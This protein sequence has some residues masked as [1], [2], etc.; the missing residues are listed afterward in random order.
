MKKLLLAALA[1]SSVFLLSSDIFAA[2]A[3]K[4]R[5][6]KRNRAEM[7]APAPGLEEEAPVEA[8]VKAKRKKKAAAVVVEA[9]DV[10]VP[11]AVPALEAAPVLPAP[12]FAAPVW[13]APAPAPARDAVQ[14]AEEARAEQGAVL[15][16]AFLS[17]LRAEL[18]TRLAGFRVTRALEAK[19][20]N[21]DAWIKTKIVEARIAFQAEQAKQA[22]A[23]RRAQGALVVFQPAQ[24]PAAISQA[25]A[26]GADNAQAIV[27][28]LTNEDRVAHVEEELV[29]LQEELVTGE[30]PVAQAVVAGETAEAKLARL[31][32]ELAAANADKEAANLRLIEVQSR[33]IFAGMLGGLSA[34]ASSVRGFFSG[35]S[36]GFGGKR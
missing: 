3:R 14:V 22:D 8:S 30:T 36:F 31:T 26:A 9:V 2:D 28:A 13:L 10:A 25:H 5:A 17:A 23:A 32:A 29:T 1:I 19:I 34:A 7:E 21:L 20:G 15:D 12:V 16:E 35:F 4:A 6:D 11:L 27:E 18:Q 24:M 33:S